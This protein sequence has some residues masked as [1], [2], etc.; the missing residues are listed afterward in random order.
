MKPEAKANQLFDHRRGRDVKHAAWVGKTISGLRVDAGDLAGVIGVVLD[1]CHLVTQLD[2]STRVRRVRDFEGC[3]YKI[4]AGR[5]HP[6][7]HGSE[8]ARRGGVVAVDSGPGNVDSLVFGHDKLRL[9]GVGGGEGE[10]V[11]APTAYGAR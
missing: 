2:D 11:L 7:G 6:T 10:L 1:V 4:D 9:F 5:A 8:I 3:L